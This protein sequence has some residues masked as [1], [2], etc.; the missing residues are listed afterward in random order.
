[1]GVRAPGELVRGATLID[2]PLPDE[3]NSTYDLLPAT[4]FLV[5]YSDRPWVILI[6]QRAYFGDDL[7]P[8]PLNWCVIQL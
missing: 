1:M 4:R 5:R 8:L 2:E 7:W 6:R 3:P